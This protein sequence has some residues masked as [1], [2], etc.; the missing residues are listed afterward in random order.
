M[1]WAQKYYIFSR[2]SRPVPGT[3]LVNTAMFQLIYLGPLF[4]TIGCFCWSHFFPE[5]TPARAF[6]AHLVSL[7]LSIVIFLLPFETVSK[8]VFSDKDEE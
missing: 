7:I 8:Y 4:Y 2:C 5:G 1:Y 6:V 3:N